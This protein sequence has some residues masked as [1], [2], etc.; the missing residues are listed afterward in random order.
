MY[1]IK[2]VVIVSGEHQRDSAIYTHVF[3]RGCSSLFRCVRLF[4]TLWTVACK[5]PLSM[6]FSRQEYWSG[7]PFPPPGDLLDRIEPVALMSPALAGGFFCF[8]FF[9]PLEPPG[10]PQFS[11]RLLAF[12]H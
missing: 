1:L 4:A 6:G 11:G 8:C 7:F 9:L 2:N 12:H 5:T 10:K 3:V